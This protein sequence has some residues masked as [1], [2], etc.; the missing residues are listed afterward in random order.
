MKAGVPI[1]EGLY[2]LREKNNKKSSIVFYDSLISHVSNGNSLAS[3]LAKFNNAFG[4]FAVNIIMVG[5]SGGRLGE[6]LDFLAEELR[7]KQ[8]LKHKVM[9]ALLY[10]LLIAVGTIGMAG[11]LTVLVFPKVIPI[12][13]SVNVALPFSTKILIVISNMLLHHFIVV[14]VCSLAV[15]IAVV[16]LLRVPEY[17]YAQQ[18]LFLNIP[19]VNSCIMSYHAANFC[20][21]LGLLLQSQ[22]L[23]TESVRVAS[24]TTEN[25]VYKKLYKEM[26]TYIGTGKKISQFISE[27]Q[28]MFPDLLGPTIGIGER[29]GNLG[30]TFLY[31][32]EM[33][34]TEIDELTKNLSGIMEPLLMVVMGLLVG[35]VA[36]AIITPIYSLTEKLKP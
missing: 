30:E 8:G 16:G 36:I 12:F 33:Y 24:A 7:K 26:A 11:G 29:A 31:L 21:T 19:L 25:K 23:I 17:R 20:R 6:S 4:E 32:G 22:L 13:S 5:E 9:G 3:A 2:V 14:S 28:A 10:P 15:G 34:E 18:K 35:F 27:H 1:L